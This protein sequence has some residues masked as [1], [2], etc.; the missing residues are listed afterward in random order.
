LEREQTVFGD[1]LEQLWKKC[2]FDLC[3]VNKFYR[4]VYSVVCTST[5]E[6]RKAWL[7]DVREV[8]SITIL[9]KL[10]DENSRES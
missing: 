8:V 3:G 5:P 6:Q 10:Q 2:I 9:E 4:K 1:P 7:K